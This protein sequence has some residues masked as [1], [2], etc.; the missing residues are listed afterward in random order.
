MKEYRDDFITRD[1]EYRISVSTEKGK[2]TLGIDIGV[3][4]KF[5]ELSKKE[6]EQLINMLKAANK[7]A[8]KQG[9]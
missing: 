5:A 2:V 8:I 4:G 9:D 3:S 1:G 6:T 7:K